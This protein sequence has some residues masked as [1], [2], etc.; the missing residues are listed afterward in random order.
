M[1][2]TCKFKHKISDSGQVCLREFY[3]AFRG[4][5]V[6]MFPH[7]TLSSFRSLAACC[8]VRLDKQMFGCCPA[9]MAQSTQNNW[10][11]VNRH[12]SIFVIIIIN[13]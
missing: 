11:M 10:P 1:V 6:S 5:S 12:V 3:T 13:P 7:A 4:S 8:L 9:K 2:D